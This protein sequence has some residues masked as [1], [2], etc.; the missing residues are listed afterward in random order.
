MKQETREKVLWM[1]NAI[2]Q[3]LVT[4]DEGITKSVLGDVAHEIAK[5]YGKVELAHGCASTQEPEKKVFPHGSLLQFGDVSI[6]EATE[7]KRSPYEFGGMKLVRFAHKDHVEI[8]GKRVMGGVS[9]VW[10]IEIKREEIKT[11]H[12]FNTGFVT[13]NDKRVFAASRFGGMAALERFMVCGLHGYIN[14][15]DAQQA[16]RGE[17]RKAAKREAAK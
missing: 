10:K 14:R 13:C 15:K 16:Q 9:Q 2:H 4:D 12:F 3:A 17:K 1:A 7:K 6:G 8:I 5:M 11:G